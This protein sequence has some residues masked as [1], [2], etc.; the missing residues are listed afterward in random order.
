MKTCV[1]ACWTPTFKL[2]LVPLALTPSWLD[3]LPARLNLCSIS[4]TLQHAYLNSHIRFKTMV[5]AYKAVNGTA[6]AYLQALVKSHTPALLQLD[7]WY[8][9]RYEEVKADHQSHNSSLFWHHSGG[10]SSLP[11]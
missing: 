3:S 7:I 9:H 1:N 6:P 10:T 11:M 2:G 8:S 4:G 5:L